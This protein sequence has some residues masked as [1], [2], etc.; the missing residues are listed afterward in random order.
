[1]PKKK[2]A[3]ESELQAPAS[4]MPPAP[5]LDSVVVDIGA[6]EAAGSGG[7]DGPGP[8]AQAAKDSAP[9]APGKYQLMVHLIEGK[10][11]AA[12]DR[13]GTSDP[14]VKCRYAETSTPALL[15]PVPRE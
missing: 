7:D 4:G 11:L 12:K 8:E 13:S 2:D 9:P 15:C 1:M 3:D 5:A 10:G 14:V 6:G